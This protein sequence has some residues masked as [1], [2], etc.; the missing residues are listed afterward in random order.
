[1]LYFS[2]I[3]TKLGIIILVKKSQL[4]LPIELCFSQ[5]GTVQEIQTD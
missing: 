5:N 3:A 4:I 2:E 1:M